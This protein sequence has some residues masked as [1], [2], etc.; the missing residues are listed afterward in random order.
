[1][2]GGACG[3]WASPGA[4]LN[5]AAQRV[6]LRLGR[7]NDKVNEHNDRILRDHGLSPIERQAILDFHDLHPLDGYRRP[8][9]MMLDADIVA[10][11]PSTVHRVLSAAGRLDRWNRKPSKKGT[12]FGQPLKP[13][14]HWHSTRSGGHSYLNVA[15]TF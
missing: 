1:M 4:A 14:E 3:A 10:A 11:S 8:T 2:I 9:Y 12:G 7:Y 15:G 13:H 6:T 5:A